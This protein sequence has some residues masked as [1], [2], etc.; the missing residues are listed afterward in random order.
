MNSSKGTRAKA[1]VGNEARVRPA[2]LERR[3]TTSRADTGPHPTDRIGSITLSVMRS[4]VVA[5]DRLSAY[6][7]REQAAVVD[8]AMLDETGS[9]LAELVRHYQSAARLLVKDWLHNPH[10]RAWRVDSS[11]GRNV[12]IGAADVPSE[13]LAQSRFAFAEDQPLHNLHRRIARDG[14]GIPLTTWTRRPGVTAPEPAAVTVASALTAVVSTERDADRRVRKV[15]VELKDPALCDVTTLRGVLVPLAADFTAPVSL[16]LALERKPSAVSYG[17][18]A[19]ERRGTVEGFSALTPGGAG[20]APLILIDGAGLAPTL[21]A[22]IANEVAGA[23]ALRDR[24]QVWLYRYA[25]TAPLFFAAS[26]FRRDFE[27]FLDLVGAS[28]GWSAAQR[29]VIVGHGTG[30][31]LAKSVLADSGTTLWDAL[32][33]APAERTDLET[34]DRELLAR[35]FAWRRATRVERVILIR[36][37]TNASAI[38]S[39]VGARAVQLLKRQSGEFRSTIERIYRRSKRHLRTGEREEHRAAHGDL[40]GAADAPIVEALAHAA[41]AAD[42]ALLSLLNVGTETVRDV[43][44]YEPATGLT[45]R[46]PPAEPSE[47]LTGAVLPRVLALLPLSAGDRAPEILATPAF[48]LDL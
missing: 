39:G 29:A 45:P 31:V 42:L 10:H 35:L 38:A 9:E 1:R 46:E 7:A 23:A 21:T 48:S 13:A 24:Y 15:G 27:R 19:I 16:T 22:Q 30:A 37:P 34:A 4:V 44:S 18:R 40:L 12:S 20:R 32:F 47:A 8:L 25:H 3:R 26:Q 17:I 11:S 14:V 33:S 43:A 2:G 5:S 6:L 28:E 41:L 36:E